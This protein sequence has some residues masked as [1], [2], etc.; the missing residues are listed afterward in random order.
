MNLYK[1]PSGTK[2]MWDASPHKSVTT[3]DA[4]LYPVT[5]GEKHHAQKWAMVYAGHSR[6]W[7]G[8]SEFCRLPTEEESKQ[9]VWPEVKG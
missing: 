9:Y 3:G 7:I 5:I 8:E 6:N 4:I 1:L 2:L